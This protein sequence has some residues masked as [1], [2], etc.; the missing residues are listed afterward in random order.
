MANSATTVFPEPV[1]AATRVDIPRWTASIASCWNASSAKGNCRAKSSGVVTVGPVYGRSSVA[2]GWDARGG[3][4]AEPRQHAGERGVEGLRRLEVGQVA[5]AL[6]PEQLRPADAV[7]DARRDVG[8]DQ[9]IFGTGDHQRGHVDRREV[10]H[11]V[12]PL[13]HPER[14][15]RDR[16]RGLLRDPSPHALA[17]LRRSILPEQG[18]GFVDQEPVALGPQALGQLPALRRGLGLV[19]LGLR[20]RQ[21]QSG[22]TRPRSPPQLER[23]VPTHRQAAHDRGVDAGLVERA[24]APVRRGG[25]REDIRALGGTEAGKVRGDQREPGAQRAELRLPQPGVEREGMDQQEARRHGVTVRPWRPDRPPR[26]A[27]RAGPRRSRATVRSAPRPRRPAHAGW[28]PPPPSS[29]CAS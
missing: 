22:D 6:D 14:G 1:G 27:R 28:L 5:G 20:V 15:R 23:H 10:L 3:P 2:P 16:V 25:H 21:H 11:R 26:R 9:A 4:R 17:E 7:G 19:G 12:R 29:R 18:R 8:R 13:G 24:E